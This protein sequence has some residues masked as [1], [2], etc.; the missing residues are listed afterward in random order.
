MRIWTRRRRWQIMFVGAWT[1]EIG[2]YLTRWS[3]RC[4]SAGI[5]FD[6]TWHLHYDSNRAKEALREYPLAKSGYGKGTKYSITPR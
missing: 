6:P 1:A 3:I 2:V 4:G 5:R